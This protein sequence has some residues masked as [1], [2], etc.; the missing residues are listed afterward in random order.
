M[1][2]IFIYLFIFLHNTSQTKHLT[3]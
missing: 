3:E 1:Q 2:H